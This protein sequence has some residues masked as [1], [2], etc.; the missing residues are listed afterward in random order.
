M[1]NY[2]STIITSKQTVWDTKLHINIKRTILTLL[3]TALIASGQISEMRWAVCVYTE[4]A[5]QYIYTL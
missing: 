4:G 5:K 2:T 3:H 1:V